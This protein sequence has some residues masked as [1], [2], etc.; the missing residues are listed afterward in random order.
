[1]LH[2][3]RFE[4][5]LLGRLFRCVELGSW[6]LGCLRVRRARACAE[7]TSVV[8][9]TAPVAFATT[10]A[11][12]SIIASTTAE[13][14]DDIGSSACASRAIGASLHVYARSI[15]KCRDL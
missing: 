6:L 1:M 3:Q 8:V 11:A 12:T 10:A 9:T 15:W 13:P 4:Q 14:S 7:P 2:K 5:L